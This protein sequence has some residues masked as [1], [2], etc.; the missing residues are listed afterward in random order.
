MNI[1]D[2][3]H[4]TPLW[5]AAISGRF[6]ISKLLVDHGANV[7]ISDVDNETPLWRAASFGYLDVSK[8]LVDH[9]ADINIPSTRSGCTPLT[10]A[11][12]GKYYD[13]CKYMMLHALS[14]DYSKVGEYYGD[15]LCYASYHGDMELCQK[16]VQNLPQADVSMKSRDGKTALNVA[17][18]EEQYDILEYL[19]N[20]GATWEDI[21]K[22]IKDKL[23]P[24]YF[25]CRSGN[26]DWV[27]K[28]VKNFKADIN[29]EGC[30]QASIEFYHIKITEFLIKSG[31]NVNQVKLSKIHNII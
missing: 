31:C 19:L 15:L 27:E 4:E 7:N 22:P 30:L 28:L 13:V 11:A 18:E 14:V 25:V 23:T 20:Q 5:I 1:P 24:L 3:Q 9:G 6:D 2:K 29:G 16:L 26:I 12:N 10:I 8:L 21:N 17:A